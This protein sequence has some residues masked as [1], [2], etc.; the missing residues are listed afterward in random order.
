LGIVAATSRDGDRDVGWAASSCRGGTAD[1][2][3]GAVAR[4]SGD[5]PVLRVAAGANLLKFSRSEIAGNYVSAQW[6]AETVL[7]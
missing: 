2:E 7:G 6:D 5:A 4:F 1:L 3:Y